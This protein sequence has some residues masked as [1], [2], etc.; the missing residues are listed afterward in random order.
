MAKLPNELEL[1]VYEQEHAP[2][3]KIVTIKLQSAPHATNAW[4]FYSTDEQV[5][6][7]YQILIKLTE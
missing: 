6:P 4:A 2:P 5:V 1:R 7:C 3:T